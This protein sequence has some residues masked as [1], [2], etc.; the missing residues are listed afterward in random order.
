MFPFLRIEFSLHKNDGSDV[1]LL[2]CNFS[3]FNLNNRNQEAKVDLT[4]ESRF[5][6]VADEFRDV[7]GLEST[8]YRNVGNTWFQALNTRDWTLREQNDFSHYLSDLFRDPKTDKS[9]LIL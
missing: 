4:Y 7:F 6:E 9:K 8:L 3:N 5:S 1:R 2:N